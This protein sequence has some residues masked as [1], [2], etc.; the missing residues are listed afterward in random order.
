MTRAIPAAEPRSSVD[1][2]EQAGQPVGQADRGVGRG[3]EAEE[4]QADLGDGQEAAG[5]V[6][7]LADPAGAAVALLDELLDPAPAD[8]HERDLGGDEEPLEDRQD[9]DEQELRYGRFIARWLAVPPAA[10]ASG[11]RGSRMRAGTPTASL[12]AGTSRVTT[13]PA[14]VFAP[15]PTSTGATSIVSTPMKAA[16][17]DRRPVSCASR[18]SWR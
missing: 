13:A 8:R 15:S 9:D 14:P 12:P 10:A 2:L 16:V 17:A 5:V 11:G 3:E 7:Q 1:L 18:R 6:E 4:G